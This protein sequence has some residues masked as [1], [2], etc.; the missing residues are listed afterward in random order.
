MKQSI[1]K[2][3]IRF[4]HRIVHE[5]TY[6]YFIHSIESFVFFSFSKEKMELDEILKKW[7]AARTSITEMEK[8]MEHYKKLDGCRSVHEFGIQG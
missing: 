8:K 7:A 3:H 2:G 4:I 5:K 1:K 6:I